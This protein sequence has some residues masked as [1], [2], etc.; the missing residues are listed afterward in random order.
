MTKALLK[1]GVVL[2]YFQ[3]I[4]ISLYRSSGNRP[5][6]KNSDPY[7]P[8]HHRL[9][10]VFY[11]NREFDLWLSLGRHLHYWYVWY[12]TEERIPHTDIE[13][14][15]DAHLCELAFQAIMS[16][17]YIVEFTC[18]GQTSTSSNLLYSNLYLYFFLF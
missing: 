8:L 12:I 10:A 6:A 3:N 7:W 5:H 17:F 9:V 16:I 1:R 14:C 11:G 2:S 13:T 15:F 18:H 4:T